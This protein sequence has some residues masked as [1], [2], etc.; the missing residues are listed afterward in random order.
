MSTP[1]SRTGMFALAAA[2]VAAGWFIGDGFSRIRTSDRYV[3]VKGVS[4][5]EAKADIALWPIN[6]VAAGNDLKSVQDKIERD[7]GTVMAFLE[8][9]DIPI[10][11]TE[12]FGFVVTD[13]LADQYGSG[14]APLRFVITQSIMVRTEEP[15]LVVAASQSVSELVAAGV[16]LTANTPG[17]PYGVGPTYLFTKLNDFKP[18]MIAEATANARSAA[19]QFA[20]DSRSR[21]GK[22]RRAN[23]GVFVVRARDQ[24]GGI[25]EASQLHKMIRV[26][27]TID[28]YLQ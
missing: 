3:T 21:V 25:S 14:T 4:E 15:E 6:F 27:S 23:Q 11:N 7:R 20:K 1:I 24:A 28:Y 18:E 10:E 5:R 8:R 12:L 26:V 9:H 13:K 16:A 19:E 22:I 17:G 2:I